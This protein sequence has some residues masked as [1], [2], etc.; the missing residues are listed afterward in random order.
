MVFCSAARAGEIP[1]LIEKLFL[2]TA[3]LEA[4]AA[5][6]HLFASS[7]SLALI[8]RGAGLYVIIISRRAMSYIICEHLLSTV[9]LRG[10]VTS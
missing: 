3:P 2:L 6:R 7:S 8:A 5:S 9:V 1:R 10:A 4:A